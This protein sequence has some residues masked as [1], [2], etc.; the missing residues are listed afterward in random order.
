MHLW[1]GLD[2]LPRRYSLMWVRGKA[3]LESLSCFDSFFSMR[4]FKAFYCLI[5]SFFILSILQAEVIDAGHLEWKT[6]KLKTLEVL[7]D[8][9]ELELL[10]KKA[11]RTH[12]DFQIVSSTQEDFRVTLTLK[13]AQSIHLCVEAKGKL[14]FE[15]LIQDK[16]WQRA[17]LK[18]CDCLVEKLLGLPS[19]FSGELFF[20]GNRGQGKEIYRSDLFFQHVLQVTKD[21]SDPLM[22]RLSPKGDQLVYT[23]YFKSGCPDIYRIDLLSKERFPLATYKGINNGAAFSPDGQNIAMM[24]SSSD[25]P[26]LYITDATGRKPHRLTQIKSLK[27]SPSW[28]QD[29]KSI[30]YVSDELGGPQLFEVSAQGGP[31]RRI[32]TQLSKYCVE[33][34]CN[35]NNKA[36]IVFTAAV[37]K[38]FQIALYEHQKGSRFVTQGPEDYIE[39]YWLADG[40]HIVCTQRKKKHKQLCIVD[41]LSGKISLISPADFGSASM[42]CFRKGS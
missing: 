29:G 8:K 35:P 23:T 26:Q 10:A 14:A 2:F 24:L 7:S 11:L 37:A 18:A 41:T 36:S 28:R 17:T 39:P 22:P 25:I 4:H 12:G 38:T 32:P 13:D 15:K 34:E 42:A 30:V 3:L 16:T 21:R 19:Y 27:A 40:R 33:P 20:V 31:S 5:F 9:P 6:D 1:N